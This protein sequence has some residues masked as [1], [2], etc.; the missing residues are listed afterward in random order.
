MKYLTLLLF[1]VLA[2]SVKAQN[3]IYLDQIS[4]SA[5][6]TV[7]QTGASN[8]IGANG[9][10]STITGDN[11][12]FNIKQIGDNNAIDF[13]LTGDN[14]TFKLWNTGDSN[15]Q[16]LFMNGANNNFSAVFAGGSNSMVFNNDGTHTGTAQATTAHGT[17]AFDVAG[18]SNS[19][20]IG[21]A[22]GSYNKLDYTVAGNSNTFALT[23]TGLVTGTSGHNQTVTVNGNSNNLS[24]SQSGTTTQ[25]LQYNLTGSSNNVTISQSSP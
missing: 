9:S 19:F 16:K 7:T 4:T 13:N 21:V 25:T 22:N 8:R 2:V 18:N 5:T 24:V 10:Q 15:T 6:D 11:G 3:Q 12:T 17:F 1:V 20:D 14:Y 23:Q